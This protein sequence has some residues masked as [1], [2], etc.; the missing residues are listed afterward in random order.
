MALL[1]EGVG[2][3][4]KLGDQLVFDI[5]PEEGLVEILIAVVDVVLRVHA[6]RYDE[7]L[8]ILKQPVIR[9]IGMALVA[10]DLVEGLLQLHAAAFQLH[11]DQR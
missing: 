9:P 2:K 5:G 8:H 11:L 10:V 6:V 3:G 1:E 4:V 7:K